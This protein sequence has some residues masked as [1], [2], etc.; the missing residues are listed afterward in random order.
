MRY[1]KNVTGIQRATLL[2][3]E[4]LLITSP[5]LNIRFI[6]HHPV[7]HTMVELMEAG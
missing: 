6:A 7:F 5:N 2:I 3:I 1:A 4:N